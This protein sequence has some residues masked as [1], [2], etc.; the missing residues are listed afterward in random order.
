M[1]SSRLN[2]VIQRFRTVLENHGAGATDA[3][4]LTRYIRQRDQAAFEALVRRH[5]PM[6]LGVCRR[7]LH[8]LHDA[9]DAFQATFLVLVR[10]A[11]TLRSPGMIGNWLYGVAYR[12]ALHARDMGMK[13][14]AKEAE[15][16]AR[17]ES[18]DDAWAELR[19]VL[20]QELQRLPDKYRAVVVLC[21]LEG[22]TRREAARQLGW[23]DGT[24]ASRLV[25]GRMMLGK[26]LAQ[27]GLSVGGGA[28]AVALSQ[29]TACACVPTSLTC[30]TARA[31]TLF[32]LGQPAAAGFISDKVIAL[33]EGVLKTMLL[34]K[35]KAG[36]GV[37]FVVLGSLGTGAFIHQALADRPLASD[38]QS[39]RQAEAKDRAASGA[40]QEKPG[41]TS[42]AQK[43][44]QP[45]RKDAPAPGYRWVYDPRSG[46]GSPWSI[47]RADGKGVVAIEE[48][49]KDGA[50]VLTLAH[51]APTNHAGLVEFRPVA[52]DHQGN[53]HVLKLVCG[54]GTGE[55]GMYRFRLD[56]EKL[57]ENKIERLG[58]EM[59]TPE[60]VQQLA[61]EAVARAKKERLEV[62][63]PAQVGKAYDFVLTTL[64]N[65]KVSSANLKGK[66]VLLDCWTST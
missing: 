45:E 63:L 39:L 64:D 22:K 3:D 65:Q 57:P 49:D 46:R 6:V 48:T 42:T 60:G 33:T 32:A 5:G 13:R 47:G 16:V 28:L 43:P 51:P 26:R 50:L 24:V 40:R 62:L 12:T 7:V 1:A 53:R 18:S 61:R 20:D 4:L 14:R 34:T 44:P 27:Y 11:T 66:V 8:N 36:I 56:P 21:D 31:A 41:L 29:N 23:A 25:R 17:T 55:V 9:E 54:G 37:V 19:P 2:K 52:F 38:K 30:F 59:L 15:V 10:K 35:L 58:V